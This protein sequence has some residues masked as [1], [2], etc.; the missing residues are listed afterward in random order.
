[1]ETAVQQNH[2]DL[3]GLTPRFGIDLPLLEQ[4]YRDLQSRVHPDRHAA[5]DAAARLQSLQLATQAN[6][7]YRTLKQAVP[8]ARYLLS[9]HGVD[10]AEESNTAM[11]GDFLMMQMEWRE[12]IEEAAL[13]HDVD[14][15][16]ALAKKLRQELKAL[17]TS[18]SQAIDVEENHH[19]AAETVRKCRFFERMMGDINTNIDTLLDD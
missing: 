11:P 5:N 16:E 10:T 12:S 6:E 9:L 2:F 18:L 15:L 7:A 8:R 3:F 17:E 1:M 14:A 13:A 4:G 19:K